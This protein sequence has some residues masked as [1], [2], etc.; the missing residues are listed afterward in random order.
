MIFVIAQLIQN[1][2]Q[3]IAYQTNASLVVIQPK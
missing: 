1:V 3:G 2:I